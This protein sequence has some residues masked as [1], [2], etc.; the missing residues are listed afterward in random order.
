MGTDD[1]SC[2]LHATTATT[3]TT[4]RS[5]QT[6]PVL[7]SPRISANIS[8]TLASTHDKT[9]LSQ[10]TIVFFC[11]NF[12]RFFFLLIYCLCPGGFSRHYSVLTQTVFYSSKSFGVN[13]LMYMPE[14]SVVELSRVYFF[15][16][17]EEDCKPGPE[18]GRDVKT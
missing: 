18:L 7:L 13:P 10:S 3:T 14:L 12:Y 9:S 5:T 1:R 16:S 8:N 11:C 17:M 4:H 15:L 6:N 2:L